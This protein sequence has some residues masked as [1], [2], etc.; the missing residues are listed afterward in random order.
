[1]ITV[2]RIK[3]QQSL[4]IKETNES[5][6]KD[7]KCDMYN[8]NIDLYKLIRQQYSQPTNLKKLKNKTQ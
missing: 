8:I 3:Q 4:R 7:H 5:F 1:M 6:Y 2:S